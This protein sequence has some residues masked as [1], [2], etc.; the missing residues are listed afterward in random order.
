MI[1]MYMHVYHAYIYVCMHDVGKIYVSKK[2][3]IYLYVYTS[4]LFCVCVRGRV[5]TLFPNFVSLRTFASAQIM[6]CACMYTC[7][8]G[9]VHT[10]LLCECVLLVHCCGDRRCSS[11]AIIAKPMC[12]RA[13]TH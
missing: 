2:E 3:C 7:V 11:C 9:C 1:Y 6:H 13:R 12:L 10:V 4:E 5:N 8:V